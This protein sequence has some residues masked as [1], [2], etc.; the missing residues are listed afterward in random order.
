M[1][2]RDFV[3]GAT[4][5]IQPDDKKIW[6]KKDVFMHTIHVPCHTRGHTIYTLP[7]LPSFIEEEQI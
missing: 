2:D 1:H 3:G 5:S 4:Y 6:I 7:P